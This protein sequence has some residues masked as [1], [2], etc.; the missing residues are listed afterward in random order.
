MQPVQPFDGKSPSDIIDWQ[1]IPH[2]DIL[3]SL[4]PYKSFQSGNFDGNFRIVAI[5]SAIHGCYISQQIAINR[6][7]RG[8]RNIVRL[9]PNFLKDLAKILPCERT[10]RLFFFDDGCGFRRGN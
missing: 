9:R 1:G 5:R 2:D 10:N 4:L 7:I 8:E 3:P 6:H